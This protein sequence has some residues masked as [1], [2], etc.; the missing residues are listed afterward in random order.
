MK[1]T[2]EVHGEKVILITRQCLGCSETFKVMKTSKHLFHSQECEDHALG[3]SR[4]QHIYFGTEK[5]EVP[6]TGTIEPEWE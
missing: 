6:K 5:V 1:K 3:R 2:I 4:V